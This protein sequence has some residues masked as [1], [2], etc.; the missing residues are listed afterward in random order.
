MCSSPAS[1]MPS[2]LSYYILL[3]CFTIL[4][5]SRLSTYIKLVFWVWDTIWTSS[6]MSL[7][8]EE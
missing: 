5:P 8:K 1:A 3:V 2:I 7:G 4:Y 6:S